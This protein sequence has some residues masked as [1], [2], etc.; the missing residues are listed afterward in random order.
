MPRTLWLLSLGSRLLPLLPYSMPVSCLHAG[1][2]HA[3]HCLSQRCG[4]ACLAAAPA[5]QLV[6]RQLYPRPAP[7]SPDIL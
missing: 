4:P 1:Q 5:S 3:M 6:I 7:R 2:R